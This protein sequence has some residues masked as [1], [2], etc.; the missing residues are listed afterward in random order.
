MAPPFDFGVLV[1]DLHDGRGPDGE[2]SALV[3]ALERL[4]G[5]RREPSEGASVAL[6][7]SGGTESQVLRLDER[8][9]RLWLAHCTAP[10]GA[11]RDFT[12][13]SHYESGRGVAVGGDLGTG[14]VTLLRLGGAG[15]DALWLAQGEMIR[16]RGDDE[17]QCRTQVELRLEPGRVG[18]LLRRPLGNHLVLFPGHAA[19]RLGAFWQNLE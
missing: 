5:K 6:V 11:L 12:L 16:G 2:S 15:L 3:S 17:G 13:R 4:G 18:E 8:E 1:S 14:P 7:G 9:D 19:D 10:L